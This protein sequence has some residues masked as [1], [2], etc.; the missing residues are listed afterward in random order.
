MLNRLDKVLNH[1]LVRAKIRH[2]RRGRGRVRGVAGAIAD[3]DPLKTGLEAWEVEKQIRDGIRR[4][5]RAGE[6]S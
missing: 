5:T 4:G 3:D 6:P 1:A 2:H